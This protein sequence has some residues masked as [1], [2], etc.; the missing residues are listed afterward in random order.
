MSKHKDNKKQK[1]GSQLVL[2]V[3]K[4][5]RDAFV[6]LCEALDTSAAREIRRFMRDWVA[7]NAASSAP[8][9][10]EKAEVSEQTETGV[11]HI[12][13]PSTE[14]DVQMREAEEVFLEAKKP[15][16]QRRV[17]AE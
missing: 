16:K 9:A 8:D 6:S 14:V 2:R 10:Q 15:K 7:S 13:E 17:K 3:D 12:G 5:E 1:K 11:V 4:A